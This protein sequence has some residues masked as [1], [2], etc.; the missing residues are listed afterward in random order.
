MKEK[1]S[2]ELK[3]KGFDGARGENERKKNYFKHSSG[4]TFAWR[5]REKGVIKESEKESKK[6]R[7]FF[8]NDDPFFFAPPPFF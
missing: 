5:E 4:L 8:D 1:N 3:K 7:K 2:I 6:E